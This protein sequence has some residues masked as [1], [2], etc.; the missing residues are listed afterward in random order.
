MKRGAQRVARY[1]NER[2]GDKL[3]SVSLYDESGVETVYQRPGL[4]AEYSDEQAAAL[5]ETAQEQ[6]ERLH[7]S[8]I[9]RAPLGE[10]RAGV[11]AFERAFVVQL[12]VTEVRG[13]V[14]TMDADVGTELDG[15][16]TALREQLGVEDSDS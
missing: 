5:L 6:N 2:V 10:P 16:L 7:R 13:V 12:P 9:E 4:R 11:Y 3:R 1:C 8:G 14:V 15:F